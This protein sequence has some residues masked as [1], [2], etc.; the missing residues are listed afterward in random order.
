MFVVRYS[1]MVFCLLVLC[2]ACG[3]HVKKQ[4]VPREPLTT[5]VFAERLSELD[6]FQLLDVR[7][8]EEFAKGHIEGAQNIDWNNPRFAQQVRVLDKDKPIFV[9]C[10]SGGRSAK[11]VAVLEKAG[12]NEIYELAGGMMGWR[13][14]KFPERLENAMDTGI[15]LQQYQNLLKSDKLVLVD[16]YADWCGPCMKMQPFLER[17]AYEMEDQLVIIR[18]DVDTNPALCSELGVVALPHLKLYRNSHMIWEH[19]GFIE[20][21]EL[22]SHLANH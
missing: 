17:I 10:L 7:T 3:R 22:R 14:N 20:E 15:T 18:L 2:S 5:Q 6:E 9:Y 13:S 11:A 4:Q 16:F 12:F 21:Q 19:L 8:P 1:L